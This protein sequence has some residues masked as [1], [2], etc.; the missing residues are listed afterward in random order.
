VAFDI[1]VGRLGY[2]VSGVI[3]HFVVLHFGLRRKIAV[4]LSVKYKIE[5]CLSE[6]IY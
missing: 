4:L 5:E 1:Q 6:A 2:I 3:Q